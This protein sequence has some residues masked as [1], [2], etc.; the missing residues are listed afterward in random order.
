MCMCMYVYV[1]VYAYVYVYVHVCV[2]TCP[3]AR[4][5]LCVTV[6]CV[7]VGRARRY[8]LGLANIVSYI[9]AAAA[10]LEGKEPAHPL[11]LHPKT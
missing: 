7:F 10:L 8:L 2:C 11:P 9:E 3:H 4:E 5:R 1:Y 6:E